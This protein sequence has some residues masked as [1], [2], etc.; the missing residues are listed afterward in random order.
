MNSTAKIV[1]IKYS[2]YICNQLEIY[3]QLQVVSGHHG[4]NGVPA[5]PLVG[6]APR[7]EPDL[8][9]GQV[10]LVPPL[11]RG[12]VMLAILVPASGVL[13]DRGAAVPLPVAT[14][15]ADQGVGHV[16]DHR[17]ALEPPR[18]PAHVPVSHVELVE[19]D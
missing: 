5:P 16:W 15:G 6:L 12:L 4:R 8:A 11:K 10:A 13:G 3:P 2:G 14:A 1:S 18:R 19:R 7:A 9:R 17:H